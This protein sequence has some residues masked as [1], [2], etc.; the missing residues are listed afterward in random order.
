MKKRSIKYFLN[1]RMKLLMVINKNLI[2]IDGIPMCPMNQDHLA[3][4]IKCSKVK[5]NQ[6]LKELTNDG[7]VFS[8]KKGKYSLSKEAI[9]II[10][11]FEVVSELFSNK[12]EVI[13]DRKKFSEDSRVKIP[14]L[15]HFKRIGYEYQTKKVD[16]NEID[17]RNNIFVSIFKKSIE[18]I[19]GKEFSSEIIEEL[20]KEIYNFTNNSVDKGKTFFER[21]TSYKGIKLIDLEDPYK[22]DFRVVSELTFY[23]D[24][25]NFRPDITILINGMPLSFMEV[26]KPNNKGYTN[27]KGI[28]KYG[29]QA[30]FNR[31]GDRFSEKSYIPYFNQI[32]V[33][34]FS[35]NLP[36][37]DGT[38]EPLQGSF[39]TTPNGAK[40]TYNHFREEREISVFEYLSDDLIDF[41]LSDNNITSIRNDIEFNDNLSSNT[42]TNKFITSVYSPER[43]IFFIRYGIVY[44]DSPRDGLNKHIIRYPQYFALQ[45][46][47]EKLDKGLMRT[48]LWH[49]Q[50]SGKT[51]F[52]YFATNVLRDYFKKN[53]II[54]KFYFVVDRLDLLT[55]AKI[56]F[57]NRGMSI[58]RIESKVDFIANIGSPSI[59]SSSSQRGKYKETMNVVNIHKFSEESKVDMYGMKGIQRIYFIDE[60]HRGYKDDGTFLANLLGADPN[61]IFIGL[62]GTPILS[63][64]KKGEEGEDEKVNGTV[65]IFQEYLHKYYYNKSIADGYTLKIKKEGIA[66]KFKSDV[67]QL[68]NILDNK[69]I[70]KEKWNTLTSSME[71]VEQLGKYI[72]DDFVNF[73]TIQKDTKKKELGFMIVASTSEQAEKLQDWFMEK[74]SLKT[75]LV[76]YDENDNTGKQNQY[77]GHI[78]KE[79]GKIESKYDGIIVFQMCITGFDAPR[80]KRLY[81]M[82]TILE[83]SLLQ[84]LARVNRPFARIP[85]GY[86]VDFVDITEEYETTNKKYLEEL[87]KDIEDDN[88]DVND[89]FIDT[90]KVKEKVAKLE[91]D[92][93]IYM[94]NIESNLEEFGKQI[95]LLD[96]KVLRDL[97]GTIEEYKSCYNELRMSHEN[98]ENIPID[99]LNKALTEVANRIN[100]LVAARTLDNQNDEDDDFDFSQLVVEFLRKG[101]MDL[102]F[103]T[104]NDVLEIVNKIQNAFSANTNKGDCEYKEYQKEYKALIKKFKNETDTVSK[105]KDVLEELKNLLSK[106]LLLNNQNNS[107]TNRYKGDETCMR[108]HKKFKIRYEG[109]FNDIQIFDIISRIKNEMDEE[110]G[111]MP[112]PTKAVIIRKM[113]IHIR[114]IYKDYDIKV[115]ARMAEDIIRLFLEDKYKN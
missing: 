90:E 53:R 104:E 63:K 20:L 16:S 11:D 77:K 64:M 86:V 55:Q 78:N 45:N 71:F 84:T 56:E 99:G 10:E 110:V 87:K 59:T 54:T 22:N 17:K 1:D 67:K 14:A 38:Q 68:L 60:V 6:L 66:T 12:G 72:E 3:K 85:Y 96:E 37:D 13:M 97:K 101:E 113:L 29:I 88:I 75:C 89:I 115:N 43:I 83:H 41:V 92:L 33:M 42:P 5:V 18:E 81:L 2:D 8:I 114:N 95:Q 61:G 91:N 39:Y 7:Y 69:P 93:F 74:S 111:H 108:V 65:D 25:V 57:E 46:L 51:A 36:Y 73:R 107:L 48:V 27:K 28:T 23:G 98:T 21:L 31:M 105:V 50:G 106:I 82:R 58:A 30:E 47:I 9:D 34:T 76:L 100:I 112:D 102:D 32:Q 109:K 79:T 35:N 103:T 26:K 52:A 24:S 80:L 40:T 44:V 19:N 70:P 62:T 15:L 49:T 94:Y 4:T